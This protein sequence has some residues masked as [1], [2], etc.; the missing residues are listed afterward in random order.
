MQCVAVVASSVIREVAASQD[1]PDK[2]RGAALLS[3]A[4]LRATEC[5]NHACSMFL[6]DGNLLTSI[7][8]LSLSLSSYPWMARPWSDGED[9]G[10]RRVDAQ[11]T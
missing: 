1:R 7:E 5:C 3:R 8:S 4:L 2:G 6:P 10:E 11:L 9:W